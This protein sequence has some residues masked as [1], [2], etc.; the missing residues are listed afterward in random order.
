[1]KYQFTVNGVVSLIL[2]P[3]NDLEKHLIKT[4]SG[5]TNS[6]KEITK[7]SSVGAHYGDGSIIITGS[8]A[9]KTKEVQPVRR[10]ET[11]MEKTQ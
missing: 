3:E 7:S 2:I 1:M 10:T 8:H 4:L 5:Q 6:F 9:D 11:D